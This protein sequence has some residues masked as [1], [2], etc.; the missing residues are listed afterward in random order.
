MIFKCPPGDYAI[1]YTI[2]QESK[3]DRKDVSGKIDPFLMPWEAVVAFNKIS[4]Y[5]YAKYGNR[6]TWQFSK[7]RE[8]VHR[9][10][11]AAVRHA[12]KVIWGEEIDPES[13]IPH[14]YAVLWNAAVVCWHWE[15]LC[16]TN[17]PPSEKSQK[18]SSSERQK[19]GDGSA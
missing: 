6:H 4:D 1:G 12:W 19:S 5:G 10:L 13:G 18:D 11:A 8:G 15:K 9:Y 17:L 3:S 14:V 2:G 7:P 16:H